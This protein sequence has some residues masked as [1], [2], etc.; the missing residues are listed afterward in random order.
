MDFT[1]VINRRD[2]IIDINR[3]KRKSNKNYSGI[4]YELKKSYR[5]VIKMFKIY[6]GLR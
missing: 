4:S 6:S 5:L 1:G 3:K 2:H